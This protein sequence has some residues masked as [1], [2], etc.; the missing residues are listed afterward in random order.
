MV[1]LRKGHRKFHQFV[2][3]YIC[4]IFVWNISSQFWRF[5]YT[6]KIEDEKVSGQKENKA[7]LL[8][9]EWLQKFYNRGSVLTMKIWSPQ[10][11]W[12]PI[13]INLIHQWHMY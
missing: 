12:R 9:R 2:I 6:G 10:W 11:G 13:R 5:A 7:D 3:V 8:I 4:S 1:L